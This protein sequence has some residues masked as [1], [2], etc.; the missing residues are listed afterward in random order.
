MNKAKI[1]EGPAG[2]QGDKNR[3]R[4]VFLIIF[5]LNNR[6]TL[7]YTPHFHSHIQY[8]LTHTHTQ[9]KYSIYI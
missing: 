6:F 4:E 7:S 8:M 5:F 3:I 9:K 1:A 2:E